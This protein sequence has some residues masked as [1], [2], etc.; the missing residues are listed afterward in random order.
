[1]EQPG[2]HL[3]RGRLAR[4]IGTEKTDALTWFY[5]EAHTI[6]GLDDVVLASHERLHRRCK[7]RRP[8]MHLEVLGELL[9]ADHQ[10]FFASSPIVFSGSASTDS[11]SSTASS[12][13]APSRASCVR[14]AI[15]SAINLRRASC[16]PPSSLP[17]DSNA[18]SA[19]LIQ[20]SSRSRNTRETIF[21]IDV[22][23]S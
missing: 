23:A 1:M 17:A 4:A 20:L 9:R 11:P 10:V 16:L 21:Q 6:D 22:S 12:K 18:S 2:Q 19:V 8:T 15:R 14:L 13:C 3:E 5:R 7:P